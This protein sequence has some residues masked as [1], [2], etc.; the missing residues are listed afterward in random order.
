M[1]PSGLRFRHSVP[2]QCMHE[3]PVEPEPGGGLAALLY[4][5]QPQEL[6]QISSLPRAVM[7]GRSTDRSVVDGSGLTGRLRRRAP[8][9]V[10]CSP[11]SST[12][13]LLPTQLSWATARGQATGGHRVRSGLLWSGPPSMDLRP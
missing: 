7:H 11:S 3:C 13:C 10:N 12:F 1:R 2:I 8:A 4:V 9:R 6:Q 5:G